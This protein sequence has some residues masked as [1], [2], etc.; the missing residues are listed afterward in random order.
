MTDINLEMERGGYIS[1]NVSNTGGS[2]VEGLQVAAVIPGDCPW[3]HEWVNS[4]HTDASG[5]YLLGPMPP[6]D[7]AVYA[8]ASCDSLLYVDEWYDD[9]WNIEAA[10]LIPVTTG[11]TV[12]GIDIVI[13]PGVL[14]TGTVTVPGGYSPE[15]IQV[16]VWEDVDNGYGTG[17][18]TDAS[19]FYQVPVPPIYD[20]PWSV[21]I[22]PYGTDLGSQWA[23]GFDLSRQASW[24][25]DLGPGATIAGTITSDGV[26]VEGAYIGADSPWMGNGTETDA[27]GNY[28]L[29]NLP[30]GEYNVYAGR[31]PDYMEISYGGYN[32]D[33]STRIWVDEGEYQGGDNQ[34]S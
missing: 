18:Q 23:H 17:G 30:P 12:P 5:D 6:F 26:P 31:W 4:T 11:D 33:S 28:E 21:S 1:G 13:D 10:T 24:D 16:D 15:G 8:C 19:G 32:R 29:T 3:C 14:V 22:Q 27:A 9:V 25:F 2:P 20:S 7:L 34:E